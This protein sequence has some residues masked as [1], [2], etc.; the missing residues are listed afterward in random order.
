MVSSC[1]ASSG[2]STQ[3]KFISLCLNRT[4]PQGRYA[5]AAQRAVTWS[6]I[7]IGTE[8]HAC[9]SF[10]M[11]NVASGR[12]YGRDYRYMH[13]TTMTSCHMAAILLTKSCILGLQY[14]SLVLDI[15]CYVNWHLSK[16]R[17]LL[18]SVTWLH[19]GLRFSA[20]QDHFFCWLL[21]RYW[22]SIGS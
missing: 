2:L 10:F 5:P 15:G 20:H 13:P 6:I 9:N 1:R 8:L 21:I 14:T 7:R 17:Y 22:F 11:G 16:T 19:C 12:D 18:T 4:K 3:W